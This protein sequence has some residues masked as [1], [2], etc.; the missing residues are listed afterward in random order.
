MTFV[1]LSFTIALLGYSRMW[2]GMVR[3]GIVQPLSATLLWLALDSIA[4]GAAFMQGG[5]YLLATGYAVGCSVTLCI[6]IYK[7]S[8]AFSINDL[9]VSVLVIIC[10]SAWLLSSGDMAIIASALAILIATI[11]LM[12]LYWKDPSKG[13][14]TAFV[15][16]TV[17][18]VC[19]FAG[20]TSLK[21]DQWF[22]P[23]CCLLGSVATLGILLFRKKILAK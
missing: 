3:T 9:W 13:D 6:T 10:G 18:N 16:F 20:A 23:A 22:F 1:I 2:Y 8:F 12:L 19:G 5:N 11:P 14:I 7:K 17:S 21:L 4:A 15:I